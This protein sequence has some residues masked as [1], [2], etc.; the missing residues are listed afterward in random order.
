VT[1]ARAARP[2]LLPAGIM[3]RDKSVFSE[4]TSAS[5]AAALGC[6]PKW[7]WWLSCCNSAY[8]WSTADVTSHYYCCGRECCA[9]GNTCLCIATQ[10][11]I[12]PCC[13]YYGA[14]AARGVFGVDFVDYFGDCRSSKAV[15]RDIDRDN[16]RREAHLLPAV[17]RTMGQAK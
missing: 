6:G 17:P 3:Q 12:L 13:F 16:K 7:A 5:E 15:A 9:H 2:A 8:F 14:H 11:S 4:N 1:Y 10:C